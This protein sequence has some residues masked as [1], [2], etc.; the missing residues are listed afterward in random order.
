MPEI[1][2]N[3]FEQYLADTDPSDLAQAWL[4]HGEEA[5]C[6]AAAGRLV[7]R[8]LPGPARNLGYDAVENDDVFAAIQRASTFS[9]F[10]ETRVI[11]LPDSRVFYTRDDHQSLLKKAREAAE[12]EQMPKAAGH[13]AA[14]LGLLG[15]SLADAAVLS[16]EQKG[17]KIDPDIWEDGLWFKALVDYCRGQGIAPT[18]PADRADELQK[19]VAAGFP[20]HT[21]LLI[22]TDL[23]DKRRG[24]YKTLLKMKLL[25][26][27]KLKLKQLKLWLKQNKRKLKLLRR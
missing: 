15:L 16:P 19:A 1:P 10:A 2:Y 20:A 17:V 26:L 25:K 27:K 14:A 12:E 6:K 3:R 11:A 4:I 21:H 24:L 8:L 23:V 9:L 7:D 13:V 5:F 18:P 22:T